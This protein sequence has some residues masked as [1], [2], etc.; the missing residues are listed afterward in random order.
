MITAETLVSTDKNDLPSLSKA[1][2]AEDIALLVEWLSDKDDKLRYSSLLI[3]QN[4]A[5]ESNSTYKYWDLYRDKLKSDNSYQRSIGLMMI[6]ANVKWDSRGKFE[7]SFEDFCA[8]LNDEKPIT[9]RQCI[10][11]FSGIVPH[12][13]ELNVKIAEK[14]MAI[15]ILS[16]R[17][18]MRKLFL[19]DIINIL[20]PIQKDHPSGAIEKY[21]T[22][23]LTGG[24][25]DSKS[26][27]AIQSA[28][29]TVSE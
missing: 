25:L 13:P 17:E 5:N 22:D 14:L 19:L 21:I 29:K 18:T 7:T 26:K 2:G 16:A 9:I 3:L 11:A 20:L 6:A 24:I 15:D 23:A 12:K 4:I 10:Q 8:L 28:L 27:K 1:L